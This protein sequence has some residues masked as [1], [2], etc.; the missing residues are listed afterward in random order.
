MSTKRE[1]PEAM[2]Q[3]CTL[4]RRTQHKPHLRSEVVGGVPLKRGVVWSIVGGDCPLGR[5]RRASEWS[6]QLHF[7]NPKTKWRSALTA[8]QPASQTPAM[9]PEPCCS[10]APTRPCYKR[11]CVHCTGPSQNDT[12]GTWWR[13][14]MTK[15][16][17][18]L[19]FVWSPACGWTAA[20][21]PG[22]TRLAPRPYSRPDRPR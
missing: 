5:G 17:E 16:P 12:A 18:D 7:R 1:F 10:F 20:V 11:W 22:A 19:A 3:G 21:W 6:S 13:H 14:H 15:Q 8:L 9:T 4:Q 2:L